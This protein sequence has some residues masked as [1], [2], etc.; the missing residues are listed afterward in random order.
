MFS[1]DSYLKMKATGQT[2]AKKISTYYDLS[3]ID[4]CKHKSYFR[5]ILLLSGDINLN[6]GPSTGILPFS[7]SSF[8]INYSRISLASNDENPDIEK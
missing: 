5:F 7:N 1:K 8:S 3:K 4:L 6:Q 2:E